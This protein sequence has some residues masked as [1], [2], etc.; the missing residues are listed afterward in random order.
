MNKVISGRNGAEVIRLDQVAGGP[1][2]HPTVAT[3]LSGGVA[4]QAGKQFGAKP[5]EIKALFNDK[6]DPER[7]TEL[8]DKMLRA[9]LSI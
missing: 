6:L 4:S 8:R 7:T 5:A 3:R 9:A 1:K 2:R